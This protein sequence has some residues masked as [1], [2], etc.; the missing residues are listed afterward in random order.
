MLLGVS[1]VLCPCCWVSALFV[2]LCLHVARCQLRSVSMLLGVSSVL[3]PCCWVS[4][5]FCARVA[6]CQLC[7]VS[8][9]LGVSSVRSSLSSCRS[10]PAPRSAGSCARSP[11][12]SAAGRARGPSSSAR[13]HQHTHRSS[14]LLDTL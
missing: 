1:S 13:T 14:S 4:A 8:V 3:C 11:P 2:V 10:A 6:G 5:L 9:L 7:S 12:P